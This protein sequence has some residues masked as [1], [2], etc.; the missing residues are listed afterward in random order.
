M[1]EPINNQSL[2]KNSK[3]GSPL[4]SRSC[5]SVLYFQNT[6]LHKT[7]AAEPSLVHCISFVPETKKTAISREKLTALAV[8]PRFALNVSSSVLNKVMLKFACEVQLDSVPAGNA[9]LKQVSHPASVLESYQNTSL[10][11]TVCCVEDRRAKQRS[12]A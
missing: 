9:S 3:T 4:Q 10:A 1:G 2:V 6:Y 5:D 7:Q 11:E 8:M 12:L